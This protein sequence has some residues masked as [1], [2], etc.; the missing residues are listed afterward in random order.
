MNYQVIDSTN[1]IAKLDITS[2]ILK[3]NK[4][5]VFGRKFKK[6]IRKRFKTIEKQGIEHLIVD[7][8][9][10]GG[11]LI[12]NITQITKYVAKEP[13]V[14][15]DSSYFKKPSYFKLFPAASIFP[16]IVARLIFKPTSDGTYLKNKS[17][18]HKPSQKYHYGKNLY[19][20]MDGGSYSATTFTIGL[21]K[22]MNLATFIGTRPGGANWGS[23]AGQWHKVTLP[24]SKI[25][26]RIPLIKI[27]HAQK[28]KTTKTFFVEPDYN[29]EQGFRDFLNRKDTQLDFTLDLIKN[30]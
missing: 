7:F 14:L 18:T 19:V 25:I 21:W 24:K 20:L 4:L 23:F 13:F 26:V 15:D 16:P 1:H 8:R 11:G 5:D 30:K 27:V 17:R 9:A 22:D 28:H 12:S 6:D 3:N 29:V 10:N 2:F